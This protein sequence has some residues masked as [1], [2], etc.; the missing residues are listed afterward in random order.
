MRLLELEFLKYGCF[1]NRRLE[2]P[3][4]ARLVV[5]S[6]PNEAGKSTSLQGLTDFLY[7]IEARTTQNFLHENPQLRIAGRLVDSQGTTADWIRR[8]GNRQTLQTGD[9]REVSADVQARVLHGV[10]RDQFGRLFRMDHAGLVEGGQ[11]LQEG[12]GEIATSLFHAGAGIPGIQQLLT[13]LEEEAEAI[14]KPRGSTAPLNQ[15]FAR[16]EEL[17]IEIRREEFSASEWKRLTEEVGALFTR[18]ETLRGQLQ[19]LTVS[20]GQLER[21][22]NARELAWQ[23]M[24]LKQQLEALPEGA[25]VPAEVV[26]ECL[27]LEARAREEKLAADHVRAEL[28]NLRRQL[29]SLAAPLAWADQRPVVE[30]LLRELGTYR[31]ARRDLVKL[32][33]ETESLRAAATGS[34]HRVAPTLALEAVPDQLP[35][36][37]LKRERQ[38][39]SKQFIE[40][41]SRLEQGFR[42]RQQGLDQAA[43][44]VEA[45]LPPDPATLKKLLSNA[46]YH[47][48]PVERLEEA[49]KRLREAELRLAPE[50]AR[51]L[52]WRG[53]PEQLAS[54]AVPRTETIDRFLAEQR[55]LERRL[56]DLDKEVRDLEAEAES[57][58]QEAEGLAASGTVPTEAEVWQAR[59]RRDRGW[60]LVRVEWQPQPGERNSPADL[61]EFCQSGSLAEAYEQ[62]V[63]HA[64]ELADRLRRE[65][66]RVIVQ[67]RLQARRESLARRL[68]HL[69][70]QRLALQ[71][72]SAD[73]QTRWH[74]EWS[75]CGFTPLS[76]AEMRGWLVHREAVVNRLL[77]RQQFATELQQREQ[78]VAEQAAGVVAELNQLG[79][80]PAA[81]ASGEAV[82][83]HAQQQA[84]ELT[85][86]RQQHEQ[87][88]AARQQRRLRLGQLDEQLAAANRELE[89]WSQAWNKAFPEFPLEVADSPAQLV[90]L[91]ETVDAAREW[92]EVLEQ[93]AEQ[94]RQVSAGQQRLA[95]MQESLD[96]FEAR[97]APVCHHVGRDFTAVSPDVIVEELDRELKADQANTT[98]REAWLR[99]RETSASELRRIEQESH[100]TT[101][102]FQQLLAESGAETL[103]A[104]R[105][106]H[107]RARERRELLARLSDKQR[108]LQIQAKGG[109]LEAF[110]EEVLA[111]DP[112]E[113]EREL[114]RVKDQRS[115]L[116]SNRDLALQ[117]HGA[118]E[119]LLQTRQ[120]SEQVA[121]R[122]QDAQAELAEI[123][124][125]ALE[126]ARRKLAF[127]LLHRHLEQFRARAQDPLLAE[128]SRLFARLTL[129]AFT[130]VRPE[131]N[132]QDQPVLVGIRSGDSG[133]VVPVEGMSDG[134]RDQLFL[135]LRLASLR[136]QFQQGI[137]LP[138]VMDDIL[139]NFDDDRSRATLE[140]L[141]ELGGETQV[142]FFTHHARLVELARSVVPAGELHVIELERFAG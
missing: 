133:R 36:A 43:T 78:Q 107:H 90:R 141:A 122:A 70:E 38:R 9:G 130:S 51:L 28:D 71:S 77:E 105:E 46:L 57:A 29:D 37:Q 127:T 120:R 97:L 19:E 88:A 14:Y 103:P 64:D 132:D 142:L 76:P 85:Q 16:L 59:A 41:K 61:S 45:P 92:A 49:R 31:N 93:V 113:L 118:R 114:Q 100:E 106:L 27:T 125:L 75:S 33:N 8:K 101:T 42:D 111:R 23:R 7:G 129:N 54:L 109:D 104:L 119:Q 138:V 11:A 15:A 22:A 58:R 89:A 18:V 6:G 96:S 10:T 69:S 1:T 40:L 25:D 99:Q 82:W 139:I 98:Q 117:E 24:E 50:L 26:E 95:Q 73:W 134:T 80:L 67:G 81:L 94:A 74:A 128:A 52:P 48:H 12:Q 72:Q 115:D 4:G 110:L 35:S 121:Q 62:A 140:V 5:V 53:D 116:E 83:L 137:R 68:A 2:F 47:G 30:S 56:A 102:Q 20:Q 86:Q 66:D 136:Q 63:Q 39:L 126:Y 21:L 84:E 65:A 17:R 32:R 124:S 3:A 60:N 44:D 13:S 112:G 135:S 91:A 87:Q 34:L 108:E 131:F 55:D 79:P 123:R